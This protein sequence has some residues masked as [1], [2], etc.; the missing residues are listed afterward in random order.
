MKTST[1]IWTCLAGLALVVLG[2]ICIAYPGETI[3]SLAWAFG[4]IL[5]VSGC[6]TF[7]MWATLRRINPFSGLTFLAA[8]LQVIL[9]IVII[10]APGPLAVA[11]P[12]FFAF[13]VFYEGLNLML[14]SFNYKRFGFRRW[15]VL[16]LLGLLVLCAGCYGLFYNPAASA[17]TLAWLVGL[18]II[19]DGVGYWVKII[20]YN[21]V[22]KRLKS[23]AK[24]VDEIFN[25]ED[26]E[27][28][29]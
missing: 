15:W 2:I 9:G 21:R 10:V 11:L 1:K 22:E 26:A 6:S 14:D 5:I 16:C 13:W 27:V 25:V 17:T 29:E 8:F 18:G 3:I 4:I 24:R 20:A 28:I 23:F 12:F 7:G 19:L